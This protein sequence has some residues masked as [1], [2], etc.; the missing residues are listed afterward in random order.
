MKDN[1]EIRLWNKSY[2]PKQLKEIPHVPKSLYIR[3][4]R[5]DPKYKFLCIVGS[6]Y[7]TKYGK[8]VCRK[9][10]EGLKGYPIYIVSG[11]AYGID[12]IAHNAALENDIRTISFPGSGLKEEVIYPERHVGLSNRIID[13]GGCLISEYAP[14]DTVQRW[15][16]PQRNRLM[17]G[18]S[19]AVLII[20]GS[21]HSGTMITAKLA[22]DYNRDVLTVPGDILN[23]GSKGPND[24]IKDGAIPVSDSTDILRT[25]GF[26]V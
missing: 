16:F 11:L 15:M 3:G 5:P 1:K 20:E 25:L 26:S 13:A 9:L 17:A 8:E 19:H 24:L 2:W 12:S 18:I 7:N 6:R 22:T 4:V 10:I 14:T 23:D 21:E